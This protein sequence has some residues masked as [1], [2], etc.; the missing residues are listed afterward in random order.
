MAF[1]NLIDRTKSTI[2]RI[3]HPPNYLI[4]SL[5]VSLGGLLNG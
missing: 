2:N 5:I 3:A 1:T 4:V